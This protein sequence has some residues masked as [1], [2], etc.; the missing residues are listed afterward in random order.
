MSITER[1]AD[2]DDTVVER[3][4]QASRRRR[5]TWT[6]WAGN[7]TA[8]PVSIE[9]PTTEEE[10]SALVARAVHHGHTVKA[11]GAG[12][13]FTAAA[14]TDG[15]LV[16]L[17][18]LSGLLDVDRTAGTVTVHGGM[19]LSDLN[20]VLHGLGLALPNLGDI[21]YQSV[22]G[23]ISTAT[24]GTGRHLTGLAG[25]VAGLRVVTGDGSVMDLSSTKHPDLFEAAKVGVGALGIITA[26][27]LNVVPAF[28]LRAIEGAKPV[29]VIL[30][31]L[32]ELVE[33]NEHFEFFWIPHTKWALTKENNRTEDPVFVPS[34]VRRWY[35]DTFLSNYAF[36]AVCRV[37]RAR[38]Q[39]I[40]RLATA[41]P[42]SGV[43]TY[44][45]HSHRVFT[46]QRLV[47][48]VEMEYAIPRQAC[49]E[50]LGRVRRMIED[51][52]YLVSFPVEVRFTA[53][54]DI[55]LSTAQGRETAYIAV[56]MYKGMEFAPYFRDVAAIMADYAG[57]PH[58]GKMHYLS[59]D[60]LAPLYPRWKEFQEARRRMDP[61]R[62]FANDYTRRV[63]GD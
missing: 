37:G 13:S 2:L 34:K 44:V 61:M 29:D 62:T 27:T 23:A 5:S 32:D 1:L 39:L 56:H 51:R 31:N 35:A 46:S 7:Q 10:V 26:V 40:P 57:R 53:A 41:L 3:L 49:A 42:S 59:A 6:N 36:G 18:G 4:R 33:T 52:S 30:G 9:C 50:A 28:R 58:W 12:H 48:F 21:A 20:T 19:R 14:C 45:D 11:V 54:D 15:H 47:R 55:P 16:R 8:R 38:P 60:D 63:F 17:D 22:S 43:S 24:H 25:Q